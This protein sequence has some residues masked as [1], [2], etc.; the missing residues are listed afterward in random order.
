[1]GSETADIIQSGLG[2]DS[3]AVIMPANPGDNGMLRVF[4]PGDQWK[5]ISKEQRFLFNLRDDPNETT[6]LY[7]DEPTVAARLEARLTVIQNTTYFQ[8]YFPDGVNRGL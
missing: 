4:M 7:L 6:N 1:M 5:K 2:R 8:P 3:D